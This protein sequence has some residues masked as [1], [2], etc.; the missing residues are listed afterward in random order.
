VETYRLFSHQK[1]QS[2][3]LKS[4]PK[5]QTPWCNVK[6]GQIGQTEEDSR[7]ARPI[8]DG[9]ALFFSVLLTHIIAKSMY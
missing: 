1:G 3:D 9:E 6:D 7:Q 4:N 8:L 5:K 2:L